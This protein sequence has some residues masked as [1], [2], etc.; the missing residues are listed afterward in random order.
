[1]TINLEQV[2]QDK[3]GFKHFKTG[4][5]EILTAL[6]SKQS[7]L[8]ILPTGGGK[9]LIYQMM[10]AVRNGLVMIVTPLLSLM[11]DQVARLNYLGEKNVVALNSTLTFENK[12]SVL[13][14]LKRYHFLFVSP[15]ML[16]QEQVQTALK[17]V[18]INLMVID[19]A[20]TM[21]TWG[22]DFR[23]DY[24]SLPNIHEQLDRPQLLLL[25]ATATPSMMSAITE[26]FHV[27]QDEWFIYQQPVDRPNIFLHTEQLTNE[28]EKKQRLKYLIQTVNGPGIV[29][30]T[31][32]K[33]A[34][35]MAEW[36]TNE[37]GQ[38][39][40]AYHA[41]M[42]TMSRYRVQQQF[43]Q[44]EIDVITATS[45]FGMGID[46]ED[47]RF[48]IH[49][50]LSNDLS[51]YL[52]EIGRAGRDG[53]QAVAILLYVPGD[54]RI[55]FNL[56]DQTI[57]DKYAIQSYLD[58]SLVTALT[59]EQVR[60]L[61]FYQSNGLSSTEILQIFD[62]RRAMRQ[63]NLWSMINYAKADGQL[64]NQ[65]SQYFG[66]ATDKLSQTDESVGVTDWHPKELNF[67]RK[68][69]GKRQEKV[70][71]WSKQLKKLFNLQ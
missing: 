57:P 25:T 17:Q 51:N 5:K 39:V 36:L 34:T 62:S 37:T 60:L 3:F 40:V 6:L 56:I 49:Y 44:G 31:S 20:H 59:S 71:N 2:L 9:T 61:K 43:M 66:N 26:N 65:I 1:M 68:E 45:A 50:H 11:Q 48:V 14:N 52:Q 54:E 8:A 30:F 29:Y 22:Q 27:L 35:S 33:L 21:V 4:Q 12:K 55:Q 18:T 10:G 69:D 7:T 70:V 47:I 15:E 38:R 42:D 58:Q 64:R 24:L 16:N 32:R 23:P 19:E 67:E 63:S 46:K 13:K 53:Q 41:G 28:I